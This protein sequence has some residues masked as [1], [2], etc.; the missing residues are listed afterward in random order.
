M[1]VWRQPRTTYT[2]QNIA[3]TIPFGGG[4][5]MSWGHFLRI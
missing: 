5:V 2:E 1:R 4:L 3:D